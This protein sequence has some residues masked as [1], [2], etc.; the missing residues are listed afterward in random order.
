MKKRTILVLIGAIGIVGFSLLLV[1]GF[2]LGPHSVQQIVS[3]IFEVAQPAD[4]R[5]TAEMTNSYLSF[6]YPGNWKIDTTDPAYD[7]DKHFDINAPAGGKVIVHIFEPRVTPK[8]VVDAFVRDM[9][10]LVVNEEQTFFES[11]G[12]HQGYG[13]QLRGLL[14][15]F[16]GRIRCFGLRNSK[17][18]IIV[19]ENR[20][21][22][23][24][25]HNRD[26]YEL[27]SRTFKLKDP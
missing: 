3:G 6:Q 19:V 5:N 15:G 10:K 27:I 21:D 24:E 2:W 12:S 4:I 23:D 7:P 11:W 14:I 26:G 13:V 25:V 18:T 17:A 16:K 20:Y 8:Q 22:E 1:L 9:K